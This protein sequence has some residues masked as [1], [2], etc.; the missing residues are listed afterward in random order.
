MTLP[1]GALP[2]AVPVSVA[3]A[4]AAAPLAVV[5]ALGDVRQE[6]HLTGALDRDGDLAL[7]TAAGAA[8]PARADLAALGDVAAKLADVL[9]VDLGDLGLAEEARLPP[10]AGR[11]GRALPASL[12]GLLSHLAS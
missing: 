1:G 11:R 5:A 6:R 3:I 10:T 4:I 9:V 8:D 7:V 12:V 2:V